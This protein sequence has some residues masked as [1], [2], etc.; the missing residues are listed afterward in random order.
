[1]ATFSDTLQTDLQLVDILELAPLAN[2]IS[3]ENIRSEVI[4]YRMTVNYVVPETKAQ[5]LL[6]LREKIKVLVDDMFATPDPSQ[7]PAQPSPQEVEVQAAEQAEAAQAQQQEQDAQRLE[8]IKTF[9]AQENAKLVIQNGTNIDNLAAQTAMYLKEQ[10]FN[11]VQFSPADNNT[12]SRSVIVSYTEDKKYTLQLLSAIFN[13][14]E[15]N[16]RRSPASK[17]MSISG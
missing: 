8:Q 2:D 17:A 14:S 10:G 11:N 6:P 3:A 12:Y 4:D 7:A 1:M 9:L 13:V 5:V 16:I 15:E